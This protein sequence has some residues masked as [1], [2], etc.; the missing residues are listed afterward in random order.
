[1]HNDIRHNNKNATLS[2][3]T[4]SKMVLSTCM[5]SVVRLNVALL[6]VVAPSLLAW[7]TVL[8][9]SGSSLAK[10]F[11]SSLT[12]DT[13]KLERLSQETF[14]TKS[15]TYSDEYTSLLLSS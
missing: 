14:S 9:K 8:G 7:Q 11:Y 10:T 6:N 4:L 3:K 12:L 15:H 5:P 2:K 13:N 1:M